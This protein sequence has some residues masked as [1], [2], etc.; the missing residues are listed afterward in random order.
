MSNKNIIKSRVRIEAV[1]YNAIVFQ[2]IIEELD[3]FRNFIDNLDTSD[4]YSIAKKELSKRFERINEKTAVIFLY[5]VGE[6]IT[7]SEQI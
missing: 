3:S 5:S 2:E 1:L 4:N 6:N 7:L